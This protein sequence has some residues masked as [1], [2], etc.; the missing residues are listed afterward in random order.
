MKDIYNKF[1]QLL[2]KQ[3]NRVRL[4]FAT[5]FLSITAYQ[6]RD[7]LVENS[8]SFLWLLLIAPIV[9]YYFVKFLFNKK[10]KLDE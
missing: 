5:I 3:P 1:K 7:I 6:V 2:N 9:I 10:N 8:I 4:Y